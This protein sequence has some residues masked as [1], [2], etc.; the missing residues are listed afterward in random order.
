MFN[1][2]AYVLSMFVSRLPI[3]VLLLSL[4]CS[5][6]TGKEFAVL[7]FL[8]VSARYYVYIYETDTSPISATICTLWASIYKP[9]FLSLLPLVA[10]FCL[11]PVALGTRFDLFLYSS[12][13]VLIAI[14]LMLDERRLSFVQILTKFV[15]FL[16]WL[17]IVVS[18]DLLIYKLLA[19]IAVYCI[20]LHSSLPQLKRV[21]LA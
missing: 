3:W 9:L 7:V 12:V 6:L 18:G 20:H 19:L 14:S 5:H 17:Y 15:V 10:L 21:G 11:L 8:V 16:L 4:L 1:K 2:P 13:V